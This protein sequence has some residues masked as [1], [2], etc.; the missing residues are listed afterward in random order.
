VTGAPLDVAAFHA[1]PA[2]EVALDLVGC[3]LL[4][5]GVG[6]TIVETE[7]YTE[8]DPASHSHIGPTRRNSAMFGP[9]GHAYVYLSYGIHRLLNLVCREAGVGEA[10]LVRALVPEHGLEAMEARRPGLARRTW[11]RGPG[12]LSVALG[13]AAEHDGLPL[14]EPPFRL[15]SRTATPEI[16][17]T[18]RIGISRAV[19]RP[20]RFVVA[21]SPYVSDPRPRPDA[22]R[23]DAV[24]GAQPAGAVVNVTTPPR[25]TR[26]PGSGRTDTTRS[27]A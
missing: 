14:D 15:L 3:T 24:S 5:D 25:G 26:E 10:V 17:A 16:L 4:V 23:P 8:D 9:P 6:G 27:R 19:D 11:C 12:R 1:R 13:I 7:A 21:G 18:P 22:E 2:P 20:W